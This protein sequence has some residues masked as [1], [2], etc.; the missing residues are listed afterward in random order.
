MSDN[1]NNVIENITLRTSGA[2]IGAV[3]G[4]AM[5]G[6]MVPLVATVGA[7][8]L[9]MKKAAENARNERR[10]DLSVLMNNSDEAGEFD[11]EISENG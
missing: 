5:L 7:L 8:G 1:E 6:K 3:R 10:I 9:G 4:A 2:T 11:I